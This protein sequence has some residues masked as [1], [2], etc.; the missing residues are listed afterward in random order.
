M[1]IHFDY[2]ADVCV[3][4]N[5]VGATVWYVHFFAYQPVGKILTT[6]LFNVE[7]IVA[8]HECLVLAQRYIT[9][10]SVVNADKKSFLPKT[11]FIY[12]RRFVCIYRVVISLFDVY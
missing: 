11:Q 9:V 3:Q 10:K 5:R 8:V 7:H 2:Y 6:V 12:L 1:I 4:N